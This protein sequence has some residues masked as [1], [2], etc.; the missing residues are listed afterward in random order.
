MWR[1]REVKRGSW[2]SCGF[3]DRMLFAS[4]DFHSHC[5]NEWW[6]MKK[7]LAKKK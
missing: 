1:M 2:G 3:E 6:Q 7:S 4:G 5:D